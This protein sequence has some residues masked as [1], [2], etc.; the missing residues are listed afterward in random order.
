VAKLN[1]KNNIVQNQSKIHLGSISPSVVETDTEW[2]NPTVW[3][4]VVPVVEQNLSRH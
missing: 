4:G 2:I 1:N 3:I